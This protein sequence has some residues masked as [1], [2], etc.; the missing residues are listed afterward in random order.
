[1]HVY[2][3]IYIYIYMYMYMYMYKYMYVCILIYIWGPFA[4]LRDNACCR[5]SDD[6]PECRTPGGGG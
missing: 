1:M 4:C 6:V 3:Y 2:T 5:V